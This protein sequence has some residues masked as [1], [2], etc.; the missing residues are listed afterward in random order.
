MQ[1]ADI[2]PCWGARCTMVRHTGPWP[3]SQTGR[4]NVSAVWARLPDLTHWYLCVWNGK[5]KQLPPYCEAWKSSFLWT[6]LNNDDDH[7]IFRSPRKKKKNHP[8]IFLKTELKIQQ[9]RLQGDC[10]V[11]KTKVPLLLGCFTSGAAN[12]SVKSQMLVSDLGFAGCSHFSCNS[13]QL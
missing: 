13:S 6:I 10:I 7:A 5:C 8:I 3:R 9:L 1:D 2:L 4:R 12:F 11:Y